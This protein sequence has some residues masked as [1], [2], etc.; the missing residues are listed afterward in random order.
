LILQDREIEIVKVNYA[1][2]FINERECKNIT[3]ITLNVPPNIDKYT[4]SINSTIYDLKVTDNKGVELPIV[5]N[6]KLKRGFQSNT[7]DEKIKLKSSNITETQ[8]KS[9]TILLSSSSNLS[10]H[11]SENFEINISYT[12]FN[13]A[14]FNTFFKDSIEYKEFLIGKGF[15]SITEIKVPQQY[16]IDLKSIKINTSES[17]QI[18]QKNIP[19]SF[20]LKD[21]RHV[22]IESTLQSKTEFVVLT[23]KIIINKI[24]LNW[25][26]FGF[27]SW[28][29]VIIFIPL[30]TFLHPPSVASIVG[31]LGGLLA[32]LLAIR[33]R[34]ISEISLVERWNN[35]YIWMLVL[36]IIESTFQLFVRFSL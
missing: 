10:E 16:N 3:K 32:S 20:L 17:E 8:V 28:L 2:E 27:S 36:I 15:N 33:L 7:D 5:D 14:H 11:G 6:G 4:H 29:F 26:R 21:S 1:Y 9:I 34:N 19:F 35:I 18:N 24:N 13:N 23:W 12:L 22:V 25:I 30:V 31:I